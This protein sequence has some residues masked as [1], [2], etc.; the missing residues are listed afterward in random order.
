MK[1]A[2]V[3]VENHSAGVQGTNGFTIAQTSKMFKILSDSLYSDKI[4]AI[5]REL[6]TNAN[7]AHVS[8]KNQRPFKVTLPNAGDPNFTIR[9]YGTGLSQK[10]M[11][12]LYTTYGASNK[13][14]SNDFTGCLGLGSKSPFAYTKSFTTA[15]FFN[16]KCYTYIAAMD[17]TGVPSL[18]LFGVTDTNEP[19]GIEISFAV[20]QSDFEEFSDKAKRVFH[21]FK[22]QPTIVGGVS[23]NLNDGTYRN[24][25]TVISGEGWKVGRLDHRNDTFPSQYNNCG[26]GIIAIMGNIAYPVVAEQVI[27]KEK[28]QESDAIRAWNKVF[29]KVDLANWKNLVSDILNQG[30]YL[31]IEFNIGDLE[32][33]VSREGLQYTKATV[34]KLREKTQAIYM[35]LKENVSKKVEEA[36]CL[37]EAYRTY[38][39]LND[40]A[41]GYTAGAAWTDADGITHELSSGKNLKVEMNKQS[42]LYVFNWKT[43]TY[44][45]KR[46]VYQTDTLH[47]ETLEGK[48]DS[49]YDKTKRNSLK[50]F[51]CDVKSVERA[52]KIALEYCE[53]HNAQA[54]LMI[55]TVRPHEMSLN[56]FD[57]LIKWFGGEVLKVSDYA[58]LIRNGSSSG[59]AKGSISVNEMF[60]VAK[61]GGHEGLEGLT[62]KKDMNESGYLRELSQDMIDKLSTYDGKIIYVPISRYQS[63][64]Q[65]S[66]YRICRLAG[67]EDVK[68]GKELLSKN[69]VFAIKTNAVKKLQKD[70]YKLVKFSEWFKGKATKV[71]AKQIKDIAVWCKIREAAILELAMEDGSRT[72]GYRKC[73]KT[74]QLMSAHLLNIYGKDFAKEINDKDLVE[75]LE[76]YITLYAI[77]NF[78]QPT[79]AKPFTNQEVLDI[80]E[81]KLVECGLPPVDPSRLSSIKSRLNKA[82]EAGNELTRAGIG[83]IVS[84]DDLLKQV[85]C[86]SILKAL[87]SIHDIRKKFKQG[88]DRSPMLKYTM[89]IGDQDLE[90]KDAQPDGTIMRMADDNRY[91]SM[92][93]SVKNVD[94]DDI[95]NSFGL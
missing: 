8:A 32:M 68:F 76:S 28:D 1:L 2:D 61:T 74:E 92:L 11:E 46:K 62:G 26:A 53:I 57:E 64:D 49:Y 40:I 81:N 73:N 78:N 89:G 34:M 16:G 51:V 72:N 37:V 85:D 14:D 30:L 41:G 77:S 71:Y 67:N 80:I 70:G 9:D 54:Y 39:N 23:E 84:M 17:E 10:D 91:G 29:G 82:I 20:S 90:M 15:S 5:I 19:N 42:Q 86:E 55:N 44:R 63:M 45:S 43:T 56:G 75:A 6:S 60:V 69:T 95:K 27:G 7:D 83:D 58:D 93:S 36:N 3:T 12:E 33:D 94:R 59:G 65:I 21:Y 38:Y 25:E 66:I 48:A 4:M 88:L 31:E 24:N 22:N 47:G 13:N 79:L 87:P 50:L 35:Q 52:K 18:S